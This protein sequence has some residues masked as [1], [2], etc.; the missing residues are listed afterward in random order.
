MRWT[1][2]IISKEW[3]GK[4]QNW[5]WTPPHPHSGTLYVHWNLGV[6]S[7]IS[8]LCL[9]GCFILAE[10]LLEALCHLANQCLSPTP[11]QPVRDPVKA[12]QL[13]EGVDGII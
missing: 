10:M 4:S 7:D 11:I 9:W 6:I 3:D 8:D 12:G 5:A 2:H 13:Y 1:K